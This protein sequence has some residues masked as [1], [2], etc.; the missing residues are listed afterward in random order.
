MHSNGFS[1]IRKLVERAGLSYDA[2][3]PF[4]PDK[5]L[6]EALLAPTRIYVRQC[7]AG[8]K[9]GAIKGFAHITGGG[10][11]E[12]TPRVLPKGVVAEIDASLWDLPPVFQWV[13]AEAGLSAHEMCRTFNCGIGMI[14]IVDGARVAEAS[15]ALSS[16][17]DKVQEV[18]WIAEA[19]TGKP[20]TTVAGPPGTWGVTDLWVSRSSD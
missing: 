11:V 7:L 1:L 10:I 18:G 3:A 19:R 6:G 2:P 5:S 9:T 20:A 12:N 16:F 8:L 4:A 15:K 13:M 17:G 14:A